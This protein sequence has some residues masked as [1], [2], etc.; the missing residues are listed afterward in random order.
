[1]WVQVVN[2]MPGGHFSSAQSGLLTALCRRT[3]RADV[4]ALMILD[5]KPDWTTEPGGL[6]RLDRLFAMA[7]REDRGI[8][9]LARSLRLT[10]QSQRTAGATATAHRNAPQG[11][12]PWD[13]LPPPEENV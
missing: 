10:L 4:L 2:A 5:F 8:M 6:E 13:E 1:M 3:A 12:R 9:A 11:R 7:D